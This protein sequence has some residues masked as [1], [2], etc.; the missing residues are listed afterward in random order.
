MMS[1]ILLSEEI[2]KKSGK[3]RMEV[4]RLRYLCVEMYEGIININPTSRNIFFI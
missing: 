3:V 1:T 2:E 4:N